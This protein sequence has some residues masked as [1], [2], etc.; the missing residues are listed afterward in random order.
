MSDDVEVLRLTAFSSDPEGGNPAGVVLDA[1]SLSDERMQ[2]IAAEVGYAET[3]FVTAPPSPE[4]PGRMG[5]RYFSPTA[6]VPFCGHATVATAVA[7]A[8]GLGGQRIPAPV[9]GAFLFETA[10]GEVRITTRRGVAGA[11]TV[12]SVTSVEPIV[13]EPQPDVLDRL[14]A[15]LGLTEGDLDPTHPPRLSFA[16]NTHPVVVVA[17]RGRFDAFTFDPHTARALMDEQGWAGT[18]TVAHARGRA[19]SPAEYEARNIFPVGTMNEDPATG[20]AAAALGAYLRALGL[21]QPPERV[22]IRQGRHVGRPG[23]LTVDV[24]AAGG[25]IVSGTATRI[26]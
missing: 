5:I 25:I 19:D 15:L 26:S 8:D 24:P 20:S 13:T 9:D 21:V 10:V 12:A 2:E 22:L 14:L 1:R 17:D 4:Q 6:E 16:G 23:L 18:I 3:A 11:G 7:I